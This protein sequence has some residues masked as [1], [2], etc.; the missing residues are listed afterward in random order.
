MK[1]IGV[2]HVSINVDDV[3]AAVAFYTDVLG[4]EMRDD[5]PDFGFP[6]AWLNAGNQQLHLIGG[7]VPASKGQHFAVQVADIEATVAELR[8]RGAQVSDSMPVGTGR[9]AFINDPSGNLVEIHEA[10]R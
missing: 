7:E 3:D 9:Q 2:H 6:G 8:S 5:R 4:F 10:A 1:P